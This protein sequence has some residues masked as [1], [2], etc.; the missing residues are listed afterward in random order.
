MTREEAIQVIAQVCAKFVG[1][2][3]ECDLVKQAFEVL[4]SPPDP[5]E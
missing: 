2:I 4:T 1:T 3:A 5:D